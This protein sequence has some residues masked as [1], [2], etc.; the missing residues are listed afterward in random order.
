MKK[1]LATLLVGITIVMLFSVSATAL[2]TDDVQVTLKSKNWG[3]DPNWGGSRATITIT[4][5]KMG[6]LAYVEEYYGVSADGQPK[7]F[8]GNRHEEEMSGY[9]TMFDLIRPKN[10][11]NQDWSMIKSK[12]ILD[13][14]VVY[15]TWINTSGTYRSFVGRAAWVNNSVVDIGKGRPSIQKKEPFNP[16]STVAK[17]NNTENVATDNTTIVDAQKSPALEIYA[18]I[19]I[20]FSVYIIRKKR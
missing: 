12:V 14:V 7:F 6:S 19:G 18:V 4:T 8:S 11:H 16:I 15:E 5:N 13:K 2:S 9:T 20:L 10:N 1:F 3:P 17:E